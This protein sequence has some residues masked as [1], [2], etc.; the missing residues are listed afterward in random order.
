M[1]TNEF[2]L[3]VYKKG[4]YKRRCLVASG[5]APQLRTVFIISLKSLWNLWPCRWLKLRWILV[6]ASAHQYHYF[7]CL[8]MKSNFKTMRFCSVKV[9]LS[10]DMPIQILIIKIL[11]TQQV[12]ICTEEEIAVTYLLIRKMGK[13]REKRKSRKG[14][15]LKIFQIREKY[16]RT[17]S[18]I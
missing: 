9:F 11:T 13:S 10:D 7:H 15:V 14:S 1:N 16:F 17:F 2:L 8:K 6:K 4:E 5:L 3:L 18:L 12:K